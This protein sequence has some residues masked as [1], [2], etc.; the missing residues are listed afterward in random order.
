[1]VFATLL[2]VG[3]VNPF[4]LPFDPDSP[5]HAKAVVR[6]LLDVDFQSKEKLL[7]PEAAKKQRDFSQKLTY[8]TG[9]FYVLGTLRR[10]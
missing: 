9:I 3:G 1:M 6:V 7:F 4:M 10:W 8:G 5:V 2:T